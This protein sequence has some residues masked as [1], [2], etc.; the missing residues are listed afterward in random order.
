MADIQVTL[1]EDSQTFVHEQVATGQ[2]ASPSDFVAKLIES[3]RKQAIRD[4]IDALLLEGLD[5]G[6]PIEVTPEYWQQKKDEWSRKYGRAD[7]P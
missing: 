3:A 2:F 6:P 5:S 7:K 4:R 1:S